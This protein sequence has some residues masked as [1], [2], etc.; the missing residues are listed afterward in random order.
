MRTVVLLCVLLCILLG[1]L[2]A[3]CVK[4]PDSFDV[5][6]NMNGGGSDDTSD[7]DDERSSAPRQLPRD[8]QYGERI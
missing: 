1:L 2:P 8:E 5:N 4:V 6:V 7:R 3:G